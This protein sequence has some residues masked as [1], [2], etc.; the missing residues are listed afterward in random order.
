M[1]KLSSYTSI[2]DVQKTDKVV[3]I[4]NPSG[5]PSTKTATVQELLE[6]VD[7]FT[8]DESMDGSNTLFVMTAGAANKT[9]V[10]DLLESVAALTQLTTFSTSDRMLVIDDPV[11]TPTAKYI[12]IADLLENVNSLTAL[13]TV[14]KSDR[15]L[16]IDDPT[17]TPE[18]K[19]STITDQFASMD[20]DISED[21]D[22]DNTDVLL[23]GIASGVGL[24]LVGVSTDTISAVY[25]V[26]GSTITA[27]SANATF[28]TTKDTA[29]KYNVYY[30]TDQYK[31]QN[32]V[33][34]NKAIKVK[35]IGV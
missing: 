9:T 7:T 8:S 10:S 20:I 35:F 3:I 14:D 5:T 19:Y 29:S 21:A 4:D 17:G 11:G 25:Q 22:S 1:A 24:L 16:V 12:T 13:T 6:S 32:N 18:A 34:D 15:I 27:I 30:E 23:T 2:T 31:I 26:E 33:G 28:S